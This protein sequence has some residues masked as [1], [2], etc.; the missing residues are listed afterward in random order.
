[1]ALFD[2]YLDVTDD[3]LKTIQDIYKFFVILLVFQVL[4]HYSFPNKNIFQTAITGAPAND[5]FMCLV[6]F[7]L[8]GVA[9]FHL[10]AEKI[11]KFY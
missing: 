7:I 5:E 10:V 8:I 3:Y 2:I 6:L 1:M 4:V 11:I 9:A